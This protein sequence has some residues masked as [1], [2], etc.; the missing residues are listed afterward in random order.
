LHSRLFSTPISDP[1]SAAEQLGSDL[2]A[3]PL[4]FTPG[5]LTT[6][7]AV[8]AAM[9]RDVG[10]RD[11]AF[12]AVVDSVRQS[13]VRLA[14]ASPNEYT[15]VILQ[16][17]GTFAVESVI[18]S[19]VPREHGG[20]L[21]AANGAYGERMERIARTLGI[22]HTTLRFGERE[23]VDAGRVVEALRA[24]PG[25]TH[26]AFVH[27]ETTAGVLNPAHDIGRAVA[28]HAPH[29]EVIL[30]SMS[31]FGAYPLAMPADGIHYMVSSA[32]KCI[33]G[34]PGFSFA[35]AAVERLRATAGRARSL[36]LD[37]H[38]Q[39]AG[40]ERTSQFRFTPPTQAL[41][42]FHAALREHEEEGGCPGR[43]AR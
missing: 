9:Q 15:S 16:G 17:S 3:T 8:K 40:L 25:L 28:Q 27:H 24:Q 32:N 14:E 1:R 38:E 13:L 2:Q 35:V 7:A 6:S 11:P 22:R 29:V 10:S 42:A 30:D 23:A 4:L 33:E 21:I 18:G 37:L 12:L 31:A 36:S 34:V 41:L 39:W 19:V 5:P 43:L 20:L 26:L